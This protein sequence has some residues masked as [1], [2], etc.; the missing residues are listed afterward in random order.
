MA[1][2]LQNFHAVVKE[3]SLSLPAPAGGSAGGLSARIG[4]L[5]RGCSLNHAKPRK[6]AHICAEPTVVRIFCLSVE[7]DGSA[8]RVG[9][10]VPRNPPI[11]SARAL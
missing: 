10:L 8:V 9:K 2:R 7:L 3:L 5:Q 1:V 11:S 6:T 4:A